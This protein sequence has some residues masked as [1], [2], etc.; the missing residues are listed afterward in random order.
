MIGEYRWGLAVR[1]NEVFVTTEGVV[2]RAGTTEQRPFVHPQLP[3]PQS[4]GPSQLWVHMALQTR[5]VCLTQLLGWQHCAGMQSAS[6][7]QA[8]ASTG[9]T[10][11]VAVGGTVV[12]T[13][14]TAGGVCVVQPERKTAAMQIIR[15]MIALLSIH[16]IRRTPDKPDGY[17]E[18]IK[19]KIIP[20]F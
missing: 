16:K 8:C 9:A 14:T 4:R 15:S 1:V 12:V 5:E 2:V 7:V 3:A 10:V 6:L 18:K 19:L 13:G 20:G 17:G 11:R